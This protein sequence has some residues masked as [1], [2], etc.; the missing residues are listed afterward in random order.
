MGFGAVELP[1]VLGSAG[2]PFN[3][4]IV[5]Q[6]KWTFRVPGKRTRI[7]SSTYTAYTLYK[8]L[9]P[10]GDTWKGKSQPQKEGE[11]Y[12]ADSIPS[13]TTFCIGV[14]RPTPSRLMAFKLISIFTFHAV[15]EECL[16]VLL[17]LGDLMLRISKPGICGGLL[18]PSTCCNLRPVTVVNTA[19]VPSR[20]LLVRGEDRISL[21]LARNR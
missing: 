10:D 15:G 5:Q 2:T 9:C 18:M 11:G 17:C 13:H 1:I 20:R 16:Q 21:Q 6:K 8:T 7:A 14:N 3:V 19:H 12:K 4:L